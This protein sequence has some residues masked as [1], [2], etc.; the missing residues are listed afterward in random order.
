MEVMDMIGKVN[1][2]EKQIKNYL[3][4]YYKQFLK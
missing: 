2:N 3:E 4:N 1:L